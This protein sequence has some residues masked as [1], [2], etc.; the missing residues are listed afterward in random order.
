MLFLPKHVESCFFPGD[1]T[2][3]ANACTINHQPSAAF[4]AYHSMAPS[5]AVYANLPF[6]IYASNA[7]FTCSSDARFPTV[8]TPN[9]NADADT[10]VSPLSHE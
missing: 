3:S 8:Q 7:G 9:G 4:C 10:E 2:T 5:H 6:P 1:T